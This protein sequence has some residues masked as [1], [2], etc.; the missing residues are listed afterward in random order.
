MLLPLPAA[1][2]CPPAPPNV[3]PTPPTAPRAPHAS[4]PPGPAQPHARARPGR[5]HRQTHFKKG[6][7]TAQALSLC[8]LCALTPGSPACPRPHTPAP[9]QRAPS[10]PPQRARPTLSTRLAGRPLLFRAAP[11]AARAPPSAAIIAAAITRR[12]IHDHSPNTRRRSKSH[13]GRKK[14]LKAP[15]NGNHRLRH[16]RRWS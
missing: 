16:R 13:M 10:S 11:L 5:P 14:M 7:S 9:A 15:S 4:P 1:A 12:R 8:L 6:A 2:P 3:G